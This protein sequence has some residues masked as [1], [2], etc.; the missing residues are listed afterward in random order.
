[1]SR[2]WW[3]LLGALAIA[4]VVLGAAWASRQASTATPSRPP[5]V[6]ASARP[7][8]TVAQTP[9]GGPSATASTDPTPTPAPS[10]SPTPAPPAITSPPRASGPPRL[11]YAEFLRR[12]ND[13]RATVET[14]NAAL[15]NAAQAQDPDAVRRA[16]VDILDFV[17]T[18]R[19]WLRENPPADCYAAA[20]ASAGAML[21]A[22]GAAADAFI[23]WAETGGGFAGLAALGTALDAAETAGDALTAFGAA[24]EA[25]Q[26][27]A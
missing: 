23:D 8:A 11:A 4:V 3:V 14:L 9:T 18:E 25:T 10:A 13:D 26:C 15:S 17:D 20:H 22:Y 12:I 19:D 27:P 24:L 6:D 1:M 7:S 16:A 5:A 21:D 2:R